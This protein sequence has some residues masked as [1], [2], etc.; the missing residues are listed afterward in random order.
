MTARSV[1]DFLGGEAASFRLLV[2]S[3]RD[4][5]IFMLDPEGNIVTWNAGAERIKGYAAEDIIGR[6][7]S[8]FY[9]PEDI[10][11]RKPWRELQVAALAGRLEDEGWRL[12][13]D[14]SRFWA[15]VIITALRG[16][17]GQLLGFGKVTRDL[18]DRKRV[19]EALRQ[20]NEDLAATT[21]AIAHDLR[22]PLRSLDGFSLI[23]MEQY[24]DRLDEQGRDFLRRIRAG[25]QRMGQLLDGLLALAKIGRGDLLRQPINLSALAQSVIDDLRRFERD[26]RVDVH[27]TPHVA[28]HGD[29]RLVSVVLQ[30]LLGNAWKFTRGRPIT[31]IS[32]GVLERD[33]ETV[34]FVR[35][36]GVGFDPAHA[37]Q[38]FRPF[39]R[40]HHTGEFEGTGIGLATVRRIVDRHGGRIWAESA[41]GSGATFYFTLGNPL[42][43]RPEDSLGAPTFS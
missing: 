24:A 39:H 8:A 4:Y 23:L 22:S 33:G 9:P 27:I 10:A 34:Y 15:N 43:K 40:L 21:Y 12:R 37:E 42:A 13:K 31:E 1:P 29:T 19:E 30:N 41:P 2:E 7:F 32:V 28:G 18:T 14:G 17:D 26:R 3:V 36:N 38:L 6:H 16:E 11:T 5:G 25:S 20:A 35:D